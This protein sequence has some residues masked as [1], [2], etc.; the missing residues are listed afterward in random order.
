M[1]NYRDDQTVAGSDDLWRHIHREQYIYDDNR[2][3]WRPASCAFSDSSD[4]SAMSVTLGTEAAAAGVSARDC[5]RRRTHFVA[6][7]GFPVAA[8]RDLGQGVHRDPTE[9]DPHH[10]LVFGPKPKRFQRAI[11]KVGRWEYQPEGVAGGE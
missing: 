9:L 10:A 5:L 8:A 3:S 4:G 7:F 6:T 2:R 11:V 1:A